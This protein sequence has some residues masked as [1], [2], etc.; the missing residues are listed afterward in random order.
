MPEVRQEVIVLTAVVVTALVTF[1]GIQALYP[2]PA[3]SNFFMPKKAI[4][5]K[6]PE[7]EDQKQINKP[8]PKL[9]NEH[10]DGKLR[11]KVLEG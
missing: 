8:A 1:I 3:K 4:V 10:D 5:K 11:G 7:H 2:Q 9:D 6:L